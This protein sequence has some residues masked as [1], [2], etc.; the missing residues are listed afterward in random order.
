MILKIK[1]SRALKRFYCSERK[2]EKTYFKIINVAHQLNLVT[3]C[4][5]VTVRIFLFRLFLLILFNRNSSILFY[6]SAIP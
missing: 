4:V 1:Q 2:F 5:P 3:E 6:F